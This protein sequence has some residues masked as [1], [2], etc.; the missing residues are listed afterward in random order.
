MEQAGLGFYVSSADTKEKLGQIPMRQLVYRVQPLPMSMLPIV[1]D[2]G[3]LNESVEQIYIKQMLITAAESNQFSEDLNSNN[4]EEEVKFLCS[5]IVKS[6]TF[7]RSKDDECSFVSIRNVERVIKVA[8]WFLNRKELIFSRMNRRKIA[9]LDDNYQADLKP[10]YRGFILALTVC[11]HSCLYKNETRLEYRRMLEEEIKLDSDWILIEILKCQNIFMDEI[12]LEQMKNIARNSALLENVFMMIICIELR[13]PLFIVGKPGSSKSLAKSIVSRAMIGRN[14]KSELYQ[15]LKETYF[16]NFQCS[17]LTT[18][19]MIVKAFKEAAEFQQNSDLSKS[20]SVVNLDEIG[21]AEGS[22]SMPL[23]T[24]HSLLEDGA[25]DDDEKLE[26]YHRV[27][28]IGISNWALDPAKMNRGL[29]VSR[30]E[31]TIEDLISSAEGICDY[32]KQVYDTIKPH[33]N[34]IADAYLELCQ[35]AVFEIKREFF[36]L[37]DYYSLMKM[38]Y[39]FVRNDRELKWSRLEHAVKRNFNGVEKV[40]LVAPFRTRLFNRLPNDEKFPIDLI[41]SALKS[42]HLDTTSR[43]LLFLTENSSAIDII[44]TY[45]LSVVGLAPTNLTVIFGSSF[46]NDLQYS[47]VCRNISLIKYCMEVGKTVILLNSYNLYESLYDALNQYYYELHSQKFVDLGLGTHRIK[48]AVHDNFRL[49]VIA[50]KAAVYDPKRFPIPLINRLEK[51]FLNAANMLNQDQ[52]ELRD[53]LNEWC[54]KIAG[55]NKLNETFIGLHDDTTSAVIL[56]L[57][58]QNS[59]NILEQAKYLMLQCATPDSIVRYFGNDLINQNAR[60]SLWNDYFEKQAHL[61]L[62]DLIRNHLASQSANN[63]IQVTTH[64]K[65]IL[66]SWDKNRFEVD[67]ICFLKSFDTQLQ[68]EKKIDEFLV[69]NQRV[70]LIQGDLEHK[71]SADLISCARHTV[72][73]RF[74]QMQTVNK[75]I[76]VL[77]NLPKESVKNFI[78]YQLGYWSCYHIDEIE[79]EPDDIPAF[80][81]LK[82][83]SLRNLL[84]DTLNKKTNLNLNTLLQKLAHNACSLIVDTNLERTIKRI[85]LFTH[86][87]NSSEDFVNAIIQR[88]IQLLAEKEETGRMVRSSKWLFNEAANLNTIKEYS[89]LRR[90]CQYYFESRLSPLLAY[91]LAYIDQYSNL[92]VFACS[93]NEPLSKWKTDLWL[94][95]IKNIDIC[96]LDYDDMRTKD[97]TNEEMKKFKCQSDWI[98]K[99]F[100]DALDENKSIKP[101]LPFFW[102]LVNQLN[103]LYENYH[104]SIKQPSVNV[105]I[106]FIY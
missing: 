100:Q 90:A 3:R 71:N 77:I 32:D 60:N 63:L 52:I 11:Y 30:G 55:K 18:S 15:N 23:K 19:E 42:E 7:M 49:I 26:D 27:S 95:L 29:F 45:L 33:I 8:S 46:K 81:F 56:Y 87:C 21:L 59:A 40:D 4:L 103:K 51:H 17:P 14:S 106:N 79:S 66:S 88:L 85:D 73:E 25:C 76:F 78:G 96:K 20:V 34:L 101:E 1:W 72:V 24:L 57:S 50:E 99:S 102:I 5:L 35:I 13:I 53:Q 65:L 31:V 61:S 54:S 12:E 91:L 82:N 28:V 92:D 83:K 16:I 68:F 48:C 97:D 2:F 10:L 93:L 67:E 44:Q 39:W 94:G 98:I 47:E 86:L 105:D 62:L 89:T 9:D 41:K 58:Q 64:S 69:S 37:R 36:G 104:E 74:K 84:S 38:L 75:F 70:L 22:E 6:Q 80:K 43:Y